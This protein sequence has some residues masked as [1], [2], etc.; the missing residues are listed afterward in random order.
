[1]PDTPIALDEF[2]IHQSPLPMRRVAT[3]DRNFYDRCYLNAHDS[4]GDIFLVTGLGVYPNLGITDAYA[5]ARTG[6]QIR[7]V[8]FSDALAERSLEQKVGG[9][10]IDVIEP[11]RELRVRCQSPDGSLDFD[12]NWRGSFDPMAE[13]PHL[14]LG[15]SRPVLDASRFC[16]LG[17]WS[18]QLR[19]GGREFIVTGDRWSGARDRSWG[20]RPVGESEPPG[21]PADDPGSGFW[22][23]YMPLRF[24]SC[25]VILIIQEN[26]DGYR[27]LSDAKRVFADGRVEQLGWPHLAIRYAPGTR[28]PLGATIA[29]T[30]PSGKAVRLEVETVTSLPL[31]VGAGYSGDPDWG[32]GRWMGRGWA[33][34]AVYDLTDPAVAGRIPFGVTDHLARATL[35]GE[36]GWGMFEHASMGRHDPSGFA[37]WSS[38]G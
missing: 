30:D 29:L 7:S 36:E 22:W 31:H 1:M 37:D 19:V 38:V 12:L 13:A 23:V 33:S 15:R 5:A 25:A 24:S 26:P 16:Q 10:Q 21:R 35:D 9:Y 20:I 8:R 18:G 3:S 28:H 6:D 27:T 17:S 11:L 2:P 32:H 4:T 14:L 34:T